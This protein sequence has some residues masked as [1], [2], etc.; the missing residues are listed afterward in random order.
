MAFGN[1][2]F[3]LMPKFSTR[4][5]IAVGYILLTLMLITTMGYVYRIMRTMSNKGYVYELLSVRRGYVNEIINDLN[6]AEIIVQTIAIGKTDE[7]PAYNSVMSSVYNTID[8]LRSIT[9]DAD[10]YGNLDAI[11]MLMKVKDSNVNSL[12]NIIRNNDIEK[13]YNEEIKDFLSLQQSLLANRSRLR[14]PDAVFDTISNHLK[15]MQ[16]RVSM[17]HRQRIDELNGQM[18]SLRMSSL[19]LNDEVRLLLNEIENEERRLSQ[20]QIDKNEKVRNRA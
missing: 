7:Y 13:L 4:Y 16:W 20:A 19:L 3:I 9:T 11:C 10:S 14:N 18:R 1:N 2:Y 5:K 15:E 6:K 17:N 8:S 12:M